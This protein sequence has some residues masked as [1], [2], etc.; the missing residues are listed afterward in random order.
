MRL[1]CDIGGT[2]TDFVLLDDETG[3]IKVYKCL[4]TPG[5]PSDAVEEGVRALA[6]RVPELAGKMKEVIHGTT[7]VINAII[8]R[9]GALTGLITTEGFR[10]VLELGRETRYA[11]YD[12]FAEFPKPLVPRPLRMEVSER[13][14]ADGSVLKPLDVNQATETVRTLKNAGVKSIAVCLLNSFENPAHELAIKEIIAKE[15]PEVSISTSYEV[16]PQIREYERTSTTVANAY[17]KPLTESYLRKLSKR[18]SSLGF[19]GRLFIMLSSGGITS[20]ETAAEFP[21]RI[22]ESGPTA[23]V[24]AGEYFSR[25]FDLPEMFC[26]DMGGTTAKSCLIQGGVAGVV[27]TFE[28]GRVQRFMKGSG[29]TIQVPVVDL[30]EIGAGGGSIAHVSRLGTLQVGPESSG[31]EPGPICYG[32][33]G[34]QPT[35]TDADL[36]LGY[37]DAKYFLGG[38]MKLDLDAAR[39]GVEEQIAKPLG[40]SY[41]QAVWGIHDLIN[42]TMAAAAKTH[43]AERGG[44]PKVVTVAAFGGA[45]PVHAYG[46]ARKL[47][48]PKVIVPPNAGV[49]SAMGFFT[50]PRAFDL[51]RSHKAPLLGADFDEIESLFRAMEAEG[52]RTLRTAGATDE[53]SF[54]RSVDAR[55]IG[56]G[57]ETNLLLSPQPF[58]SL[59]P[60]DLRRQF[61]QNYERLY[62]RT[63][64]EIPIEF[65]NFRVRASLPAHPL[66]LQKLD[67]RTDDIAQAVKGDRLAFSGDAKDFIPFTVYDRYKLYPG[68][69]FPGPAIIEERESTIIVGEGATV[70]VD[71]YGFLWMEMPTE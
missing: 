58:P 7:L 69:A 3:G 22:I 52:E 6:E 5:D 60:S 13:L 8:E 61:D 35:V 4:T 39:R 15:F 56:Q 50:A 54:A 1:G 18:L 9:K 43:I 44:N 37:L 40:V 24:I 26:F 70:S 45:G 57:S 17:V 49:G 31:A 65:V 38:E 25:L 32:R 53:I 19:G 30:M 11:P 51:V 34:K 62:G 12:V 14:R 28:V 59:N 27:P 48:A 46:L 63:Y 64:P 21:V 67:A 71:Q 16:L 2:F 42:E 29:L 68:A 33:G 41:I 20:V 66:K 10:D 36:L 47:G 55:F 23:A